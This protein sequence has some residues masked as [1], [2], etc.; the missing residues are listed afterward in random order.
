LPVT[1]API[2]IV[3]LKGRKPSPAVQLFI[4]HARNVA[5]CLSKRTV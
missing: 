5:R 1:G 4:D 2:G 3:T